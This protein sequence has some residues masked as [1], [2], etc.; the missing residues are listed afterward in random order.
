[1]IQQLRSRAR[2]VEVGGLAARLPLPDGAPDEAIAREA[3]AFGLGP[4][5]L[6]PWYASPS[7]A[8]SGL[9]LGVA[10]S[11]P[12]QLDRAFDRLFEVIDRFR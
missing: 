12:Q 1:L 6:S 3:R 10:T 2:D 11:P 4:V 7:S 8:R 9:L 5:P